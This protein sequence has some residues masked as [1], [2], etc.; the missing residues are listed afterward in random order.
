MQRAMYLAWILAIALVFQASLNWDASAQEGPDLAPTASDDSDKELPPPQPPQNRP[1]PPA[2]N[3]RAYLGVTFDA[4]VRDAAVV[5][6]VTPGSPAYLSGL[7]GGDTIVALNGHEVN[8]YEDVIR[9]VG[10]MKPGDLLD[11]KVTRRVTIET[12]AVLN[13]APDSQPVAA[14]N[15]ENDESRAA[16]AGDRRRSGTG[17]AGARD[18][19]LQRGRENSESQTNGSNAAARGDNDD[20]DDDDRD[21]G[22]RG[23][24]LRRRG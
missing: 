13:N 10:A 11:I 6:S 17:P 23:R 24:L 1:Q 15:R 19:R 5:R 2:M 20:D 7:V 18:N 21:R 22:F 16:A 4:R 14:R 8:S 9:A 12:Q 3:A